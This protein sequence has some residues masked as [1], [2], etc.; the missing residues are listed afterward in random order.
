VLLRITRRADG[1]LHE[2]RTLAVRFVPMTGGDG[3]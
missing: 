1:S 3:Q 2:E